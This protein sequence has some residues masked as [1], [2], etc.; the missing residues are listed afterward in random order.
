MDHRDLFYQPA[1]RDVRVRYKQTVLG[2]SW[3]ILRSLLTMVVFTPLLGKLARVRP[4]GEPYAIFSYAGL[5]PWNFFVSTATNSSNRLVTSNNLITKVYFPWL[6]VLTAAVG[7]A[8]GW[9]S[10]LRH[11]FCW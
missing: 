9:I 10:P 6:L 5:L 7:A 1:W 11:A 4:E 3:A 2:V 8:L